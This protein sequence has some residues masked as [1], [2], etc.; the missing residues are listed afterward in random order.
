MHAML[1]GWTTV[2]TAEQAEYLARELV[3]AG[4]AACVQV[5]AGIRSHYRWQGHTKAATEH[6]LTIKFLPERLT[7]LNEW[8]EQQHPYDTPEWVVVRA[9]HVAEKYLSWA[10]ANSSS[11]PL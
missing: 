2:A 10:R 4:L 3:A 8:I 6:R 9:E 7:D 1:I 5:E 11:L